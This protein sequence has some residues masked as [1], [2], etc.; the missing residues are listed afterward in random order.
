MSPLAFS[1][2]ADLPLSS[3]TRVLRP[4]R[5]CRAPCDVPLLKASNMNSP[6]IIEDLTCNGS[7]GAD[8]MS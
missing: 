5:P 2:P 7:L 6:V 8:I 4:Q 1:V 3:H